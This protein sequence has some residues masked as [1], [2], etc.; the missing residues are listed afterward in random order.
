M[1]LS[2]KLTLY[3]T[4]CMMVCGYLI[5]C[6]I[7]GSLTPKGDEI[8]FFIFSYIVGLIY[9]RLLELLLPCLNNIPCMIKKSWR[10]VSK[11]NGEISLLAT[12]K[13][14][15]KAYYYLMRIQSLNNIPTLEAQVAFCKDIFFILL[16]LF[17][18]LVLGCFNDYIIT[19]HTCFW[20]TLLFV[21]IVMLPIVWYNTQMKIHHLVWEGYYYLYGEGA[22]K[23]ES[24]KDIK[25]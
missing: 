16:F 3:D 7:T 5:L 10:D 20:G 17:A 4:L 1:N 25:P 24:P 6:I 12:K 23:E 11:E 19:N 14:Y 13:C 21:I 2:S 15:Y 9:H 8:V 22:L 18:S